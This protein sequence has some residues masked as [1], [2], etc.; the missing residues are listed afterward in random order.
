MEVTD[1]IYKL[2]EKRDLSDFVVT[3]TDTNTDQVRFSAD[4][5]DLY[6]HWEEVA[7]SIFISKGQRLYSTTITDLE[8]PGNEIDAAVS[9][10]QSLPENKNFY[11]ISNEKHSYSGLKT[12]RKIGANIGDAA[13]A[14]IHGAFE[15]GAD[16]VSGL[17]YDEFS[18][19]EIKTQ[20]NEVSYT[21]GGLH[22]L[23]RAFIGDKTGQEATHLGFE[24]STLG[25]LPEEL[26]THA[27]ETAKLSSK[28]VEGKPGKYR[29]IM[30]PHLLGNLLSYGSSLFSAYSVDSGV[31]CF[32]D[33]LGQ[34]I[35]SEHVNLL[36]DPLNF[37]GDGAVQV[38]EEG[39]PTRNTSIID[40][41]YLK[42]YL[43]SSSTARKFD[44]KTTGHA[45]VIRPQPWQ[46]NLS[47]GNRGWEKM[48][49]ELD[50]GLLIRNAWYTRFQ[51]YRNGVFSTVPRDGIFTV[52]KGEITGSVKGIRISDS[53]PNILLNTKEVSKEQYN[54]KWWQEIDPSFIPYATVDGVTISKSF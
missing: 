20:S 46:L 27:A 28:V 11:G 9:I 26:G 22:L 13:D 2:L 38:D 10:M 39:T 24:N 32:V 31:S 29:V 35:A 14:M 23:I 40:N 8:S 49:D 17:I 47:P 53:I 3:T 15:A 43:H 34:K 16:R 36:D 54:V 45:G 18:S 52:E 48:L 33:K 21:K 37:H 6:N 25:N 51:D 41:G 1:R 42:T 30:G 44:S 7:A 4:S 5:K 19:V 12:Y 50:S